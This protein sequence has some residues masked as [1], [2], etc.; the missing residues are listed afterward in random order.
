MLHFALTAL[1]FLAGPEESLRTAIAVIEHQS[2]TIESWE[3]EFSSASPAITP[4]V[5]ETRG[6]AQRTHYREKR[7]GGQYRAYREVVTGEGRTPPSFRQESSYNGA[8]FRRLELDERK[9]RTGSKPLSEVSY[10]QY[11]CGLTRPLNE[12]LRDVAA[13]GR[14]VWDSIDGHQVLRCEL[15]LPGIGVQTHYLDPAQQWQ[16]RR[17]RL[18]QPVPRGTYPDGRVRVITVCETQ[19]F[20]RQDGVVLPGKVRLRVTGI[21]PDG[22]EFLQVEN[23]FTLTKLVVNPVIADSEFTIEFPEGTRVTDHDQRVRYTVGVPGSEVPMRPAST[24]PGARPGMPT[25]Q[26]T[27]WYWWADARIWLAVGGAS[28]ACLVWAIWRRA[29]A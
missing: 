14:V 2:D 16:P 22:R 29:R 12:H 7:R 4:L 5:G 21:M 13:R 23:N 6:A 11:V 8:V 15:D 28:A 3:L 9:G 18:D 26:G 19:E 24:P 25:P 10:A 1:A 27:A 17:M 20:N